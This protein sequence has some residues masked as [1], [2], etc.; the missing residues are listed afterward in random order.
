MRLAE[1]RAGIFVYYYLYEYVSRAGLQTSCKDNRE[2]AL[3]N[4][5][6]IEGKA[7]LAIETKLFKHILAS[8]MMLGCFV[9][10]FV[11]III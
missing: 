6:F 9:S 10:L 5:S 2:T 8:E 7:A 4:M 11:Q 3:K 1:Q